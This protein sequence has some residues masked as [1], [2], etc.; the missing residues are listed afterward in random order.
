MLVFCR[1]KLFIRDQSLLLAGKGMED[2]WRGVLNITYLFKEKGA[3]SNALSRERAEN[4]H[5]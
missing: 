1:K 5:F 2:I 4:S 3:N